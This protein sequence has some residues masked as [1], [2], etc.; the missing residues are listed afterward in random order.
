MDSTGNSHLTFDIEDSKFQFV[1]CFCDD[2]YYGLPPD[3]KLCMDHA[4]CDNQD[5][6]SLGMN[7]REAN[8]HIRA[9]RGY[10]A[11]PSH[12]LVGMG[13]GGYPSHIIACRYVG[14]KET[15]CDDDG[16]GNLCV[17]SHDGRKCDG[18]ANNFYLVFQSSC[19]ECPGALGKVF[20][21]AATI[22]SW[23]VLI[24]VSYLVGTRGTAFFK[25]LLFFVQ[26]LRLIRPPTPSFGQGVNDFADAAFRLGAIGMSCFF[27]GYGIRED[28]IVTL[29]TPIACILLVLA[30]YLVGIFARS[31]CLYRF[32]G[33]CA[34]TSTEDMISWKHRNIRSLIFLLYFG[35]MGT[36]E[37]VLFPIIC[38]EDPGTH[39]NFMINSASTE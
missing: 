9:E 1:H 21:I 37:M 31:M 36:S 11:T 4:L 16:N 14:T 29:L 25:I 20:F 28:Y 26:G 27:E 34:P 12:S 39:L 3:C 33:I 35:Y 13:A 5:A 23:I 2:G 6:S 7:A 17:D 19:Y 15:P 10:W 30:I 8:S 38:E 24:I 18:C 32:P 22:A